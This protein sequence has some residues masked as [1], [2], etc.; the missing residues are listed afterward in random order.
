MFRQLRYVLDSI[1]QSR[2]RKR[3]HV[4]PVVQILPKFSRLDRRRQFLVRR[5]NQPCIQRNSSRSAH[6]FELPFLQHPQQLRLQFRREFADLVQKQRSALRHFDFP[7][8]LRRSSRERTFFMSKQFAL[9]QIFR[10]R[11]AINRHK[12]IF[13]AAAV[14]V[15][16]SRHQLFSGP[17]LTLDQHRGIRCRHPSHEFEYFLHPGAYPDHVVLQV[18]FR[19]QR[20][21]LLLEPFP[22]PQVF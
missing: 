9:Q 8:F 15:N 3:H 17:A 5:R 13:R 20:L 21:V 4:Q 6:A 2:H 1:A 19:L 12:G 16:C 11:R 7:L 14:V 18:H 10:N 22:V